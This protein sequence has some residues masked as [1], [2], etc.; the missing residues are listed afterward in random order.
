[1]FASSS[2]FTPLRQVL[3]NAQSFEFFRFRPET[4]L[5][6]SMSGFEPG[7]HLY[8]IDAELV[9]ARTIF[10]LS[11]TKRYALALRTVAKRES[12][13][14]TL[15]SVAAQT[16]PLSY[17]INQLVYSVDVSKNADWIIFV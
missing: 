15:F 12:S 13:I 9:G 5:K 17:S 8:I 6:N 1:M 4:A 10:S 11:L 7:F 2:G 14:S 16:I 3:P